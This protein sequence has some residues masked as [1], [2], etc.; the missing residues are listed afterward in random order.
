MNGNRYESPVNQPGNIITG[1]I[2]GP[3]EVYK[4]QRTESER[5][6]S[7][8][9]AAEGARDVQDERKLWWGVGL[10]LLGS[11]L[12]PAGVPI[13]LAIG[14]I[15]GDLGTV[16]GKQAEDYFVSTDVGKYGTSDTRLEEFNKTLQDYD[17]AQLWTDV[18]DVGKSALFAYTMGT[19]GFKG[20]PSTF[21]PTKWGGTEG[22]RTKDFLGNTF[23]RLFSK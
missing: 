14:K 4:E 2:R 6:A 19:E 20:K 11:L 9:E 8:S 3:S 5:F 12:G 15:V 18:M 21:S 22:I 1:A 13:G 17:K 23:D 16:G 10:S 7:E